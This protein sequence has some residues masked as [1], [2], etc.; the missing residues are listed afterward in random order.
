MRDAARSL[1]LQ[2][3]VLDASTDGE[4]DAAFEKL[5]ELR[6]GAL[7]VSVDAFLFSQRDQIV[8]LAVPATRCLQFTECAS[9]PPPAA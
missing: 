3:H 6:A 4:I 2:L 8:A 9:S 7:I 1:G 5:I